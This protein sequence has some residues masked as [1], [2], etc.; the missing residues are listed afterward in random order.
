MPR[1]CLC[2]VFTVAT[3]REKDHAC[4]VVASVDAA[5]RRG[6]AG[7][8]VRI[9]GLELSSKDLAPR[10]GK[11]RLGEIEPRDRLDECVDPSVDLDSLRRRGAVAE[12]Q[13]VDRGSH[14]LVSHGKRRRREFTDLRDVAARVELAL[15]RRPQHRA[16]EALGSVAQVRTKHRRGHRRDR[17]C[18]RLLLSRQ[19]QANGP[20]VDQGQTVADGLPARQKVGDLGLQIAHVVAIVAD[21]ALVFVVPALKLRKRRNSKSRQ[22][23]K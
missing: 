10:F 2:V 4:Y 14:F 21:L 7:V 6:V 17:L 5:D 3:R 11:L 15:S 12:D 16:D 9:D 22:C 18:G 13:A 1:V 23:C 19:A 8:T 20:I